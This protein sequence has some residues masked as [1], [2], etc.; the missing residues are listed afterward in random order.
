ML[1]PDLAIVVVRGVLM[2]ALCQPQLPA[3]RM[4]PKYLYDGV[5]VLQTNLLTSS[6]NCGACNSPCTG[7]SNAAPACNGG[8][9]A[10]G[11]CNANYGNCNGNNTDG[12]EVSLPRAVV[13]AATAA[14][15]R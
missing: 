11:T 10:L 1:Q 15:A 3:C 2:S 14:T 4:S 8:T 5:A 7:F 9:C 12:C 13:V 6:T